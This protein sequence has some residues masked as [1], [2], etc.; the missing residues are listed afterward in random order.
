MN[1]SVQVI[2]GQDF[3][4]EVAELALRFKRAN[5]PVLQLMNMASKAAESALSGL[6]SEYKAPVERAVV[7]ALEA[8]YG[9]AGTAP[10]LGNRGSMAAVLVSG[11]VGGTGGF[12]TVIA[13]LPVTITLIL[14]A[15]QAEAREAG[16]NP[17]EDEIRA[18]CLRVFDA[19]SPIAADDGI[20][21]SFIATRLALTGPTVQNLIRAIAPKLAIVMGQKVAAQAVPVVGAITGAAF[22][23]AFLN[24]YRD[25]AR[26][27]FGLRRLAEVHGTD[28]VL[29]AFRA[30]IAPPRI[31]RA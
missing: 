6:P 16:Y 2:S 19:G 17:E 7:Q 25:M 20:N 28:A 23:A 5:G 10:S 26:I 29:E 27:R 8:A 1:N 22:N 15:I 21:T 24:Y 30:A 3:E 31:T 11:A 14:N 9:L 18:E 4:P 13:E 12:A